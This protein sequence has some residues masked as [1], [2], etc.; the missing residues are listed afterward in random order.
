[1]T[2][3]ELAERIS[4]RH[5]QLTPADV[6]RVCLLILSQCDDPRELVDEARLLQSWHHASFL[7]EAVTDQHAAVAEELDALGC[8]GAIQPSASQVVA[9]LRAV[10]VQS[11]ILDLFT[12]QTALA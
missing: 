10:K 8:D 5:P 9:L 4:N 3:H 6:A 7:L 1:M 12:E 11:Q 2:C